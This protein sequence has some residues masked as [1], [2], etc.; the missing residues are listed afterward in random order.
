MSKKPIDFVIDTA[1]TNGP[2][3][4]KYIKN[5]PEVLLKVTP[6]IAIATEKVKKFQDNRKKKSTPKVDVRKNKYNEYKTEILINLSD[7][8]RLQLLGHKNE[9][10]SFI[11]QIKNEE[12]QEL[13]LK[14]PL[15]SKRKKEWEK[16]LIQI[17]DKIALLDYQEFIRV[18]NNPDLPNLYF[19]GLER[20]LAGFRKMILEDDIEV[21]RNY[22]FE[23]TGKKKEDIAREFV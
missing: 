9:V 10:E 22:V 15:H 14:K 20:Q 7:Y 1:K 3:V 8:T 16:I 6:F 23:Q 17:K 2:K 13:A 21:I 19:E 18:F 5:N 4:A 11:E 12:M